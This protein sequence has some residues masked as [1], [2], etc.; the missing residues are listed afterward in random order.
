MAIL[1]AMVEFGDVRRLCACMALLARNGNA[2][3]LLNMS[4]AFALLLGRI[5]PRAG[6]A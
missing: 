5:R 2:W 6:P 3:S 4:I 1:L